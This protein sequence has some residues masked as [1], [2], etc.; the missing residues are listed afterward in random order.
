MNK[1]NKIMNKIM[2]NPADLRVINEIVRLRD[3]TGNFEIM[4]NDL[5]S[6]SYSLDLVY[7]DSYQTKVYAPISNPRSTD[8]SRTN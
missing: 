7:Y 8:D 3:I 2:L 1:V 4:Y 5:S 6:T